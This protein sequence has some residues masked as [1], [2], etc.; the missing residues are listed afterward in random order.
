MK[1]LNLSLAIILILLPTTIS[2]AQEKVDTVMQIL[3]EIVIEAPKVIHK[4]DMDVYHPST[5]AVENSK[6]GMQLLRNLMIPSLDVNDVMGSITAGGQSV[7]V[8]INGRVSSIEQVKNLLPETIKRVEWIDN[9]GLRYGGVNY[10]INF[11]VSNPT[12]GGSLMLSGI[13]ALNAKW[14]EYQADS[15]FNIGKSQWS[16]G[17]QFKLSEDISVHRDYNETFTYPDGHT[18][19]RIETPLGGSLDNDILGAWINYSYIKPD[20]TVI[21]LGLQTNGNTSDKWIYKGLLSLSDESEDI[22]LTTKHG[23][24]GQ[25]PSFSA[26]LE[27]HF[28]HK[29]TLVVDFG[30]SLFLG[31]SFSDYFEKLPDETYYI[32]DIPTYIKDRNQSYGIEADY[33]KN[34]RNSRFTAGVSYNANLNRSEYKNLGGEIFHQRQDKLYFF[35]EYFQRI[36]KVTLT[37]GLGVQYNSYLFKETDQGNHS[38]NL[39]PQATFTYS[40]NQDHQFRLSFSSWQSNPSLSQTNIVPQQLDGFQWQIGSPDLKTSSSYNLTFRYSFNLPR[41]SGSFGVRG[42][43]SPNAI[44]PFMYWD[45]NRLITSFENS[46]G[47]SSL[48]LWLSPQIEIVSHWFV[49]SGTIQYRAERMKGTGYKLYNHNWNGNVTGSLMH[50]GFVLSATYRKAP[51]ELWG[52]RISWGEDLSMIDLSYNWKDWQF[53][54]GIIM[55]FGKYDQGSISYNKWNRNEQHLRLDMRRMFYLSISYDLQW[56][57]QKRGAFKL[58]DANVNADQ[59]KA[60]GR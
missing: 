54:A 41:V 55:P 51:R 19:T 33:I 32:T 50:W 21:Y 57:R 38:W 27:H 1:I 14:G 56:G 34:W 12:A 49:V 42:F 47:L 30:A 45:E 3:Q 28:P 24:T 40:L 18:L 46:D 26:Y 13:Q 8:R 35:G 10:V 52:E 43:S 59:S 9:P 20:T 6:N 48:S 2:V 11:I 60:V 4:A 17:G 39:R 5:S 16:V 23:S 36:N 53:G 58:I 37:A 44:T 7:Q 31:H 22:E 15:K 25:T 29:Q